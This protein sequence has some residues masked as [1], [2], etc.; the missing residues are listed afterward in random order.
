[1]WGFAGLLVLLHSIGAVV[2]P[3]DGWHD[4]HATLRQPATPHSPVCTNTKPC[5]THAALFHDGLVRPQVRCHIGG[6][7]LSHSCW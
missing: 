6:V 7:V 2:L 5:S 1:M 3:A 4:T